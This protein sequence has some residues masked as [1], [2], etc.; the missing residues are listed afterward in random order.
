MEHIEDLWL[1]KLK[2]ASDMA[3][4]LARIVGEPDSLAA[5]IADEIGQVYG[6]FL[7]VAH[8]SGQ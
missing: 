6:H 3:D 5:C 8:E 4:E 2:D 1:E 7:H